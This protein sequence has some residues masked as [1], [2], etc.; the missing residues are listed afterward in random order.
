MASNLSKR[1]FR[2]LQ[3][4]GFVGKKQKPPSEYGFNSIAESKFLQQHHLYVVYSQ[5]MLGYN[6]SQKDYRLSGSAPQNDFGKAVK[7]ATRY[8]K[9]P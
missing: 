4:E 5:L 9:I 6:P 3:K 1:V 8:Q 2:H 7:D